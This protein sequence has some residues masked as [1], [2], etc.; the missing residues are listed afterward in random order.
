MGGLQKEFFHLIVDAVFDPAFGMF[1][2]SDETHCFWFNSNEH[3]AICITGNLM[4]FALQVLLWKQR[5]NLN[6]WEYCWVTT[7]VLYS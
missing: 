6:W 3:V 2:Y 5:K 1:V 7:D 4:Y